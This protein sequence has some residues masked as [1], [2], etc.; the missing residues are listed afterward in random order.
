MKKYIVRDKDT[1]WSISKSTG[2]R[3]NLLMAANPQIH[4]P[5]RLRPGTV[6]VI[7]EL[8]KGNSHGL[9]EPGTG[10]SGTAAPGTSGTDMPVG[11]TT[12]TPPGSAMPT[13]QPPVKHPTDGFGT[14]FF[15]FVWPHV[16]KPGETWEA[17]SQRY[18]VN[19]TRLKH[20][21]PLHANAALQE[22]DIIYI[23]GGHGMKVSATTAPHTGSSQVT[24]MPP[25]TPGTGPEMPTQQGIQPPVQGPLAGYELGPHTHYPYRIAQPSVP[26]ATYTPPGYAA[27]VSPYQAPYQTPSI[28]PGMWAYI[29]A[30]GNGYGMP[31][32]HGYTSN[33]MSPYRGV[34]PTWYTD[35]DESSS[36]ESSWSASTVEPHRSATSQS[37]P[38]GGQDKWFG[39]SS[40]TT[41][42][43]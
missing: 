19:V 13:A 21:N 38:D 24:Q 1:M 25:V 12:P 26:F 27:V 4:D 43:G 40:G 22:G 14:Q 3:L 39:E 9:V 10:G 34:P 41:K 20:M 6:I 8:H 29:P 37:E 16:I 33:Q 15:G 5:N 36:W 7:P 23:P 42:Q 11:G 18:K 28:P 17:V 35:W 30:P 32:L 2:V 31:R